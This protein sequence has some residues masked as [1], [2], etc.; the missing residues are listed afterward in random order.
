VEQE[1]IRQIV[2]KVLEKM[3]ARS[4]SEVHEIPFSVGISNRHIHLSQR[5]LEYLFGQGHKLQNLKN[6]SQPGQYAARETVI[7]AGPKGCIEQVRVLGPV[8][9]QTQVEIL[10]SDTFKLGVNA[11]VRESGDLSGSA[12][13]TVI[14][15]NGSI[16]LKEGL[17]I[18]QRH[19]HMKPSDAGSYGVSDGQSVRVRVAGERGILFENVVVRVSDSYASDFHID[20]DE[21]NGAGIKP[22]DPAYL[23]APNGPLNFGTPGIPVTDR[24]VAEDSLTLVTEA[25]VRSAWEKKTALKIR[26]N[27]VCTPLARD[28][29]KELGVDVKWDVE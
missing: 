20:I 7:L 4:L 10:R 26:K 13:I 15:P 27:A 6:I 28:V 12:G 1:I 8:R 24:I 18:A 22:G 11:P 19:L 5:D 9:K 17:I 23:V 21:A 25:A 16:E 14:G 3:T 29:I 2:S